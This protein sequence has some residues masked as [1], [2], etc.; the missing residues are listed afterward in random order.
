MIP[1]VNVCKLKN[2][3]LWITWQQLN[4]LRTEHEKTAYQSYY[5]GL[6]ARKLVWG[7]TNNS[8]ISAFVTRLLESIIP[9]LGMREIS[10]F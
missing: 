3:I 9:R 2:Y 6:D 4:M 1:K 10:I 7:V 5:M 8:L